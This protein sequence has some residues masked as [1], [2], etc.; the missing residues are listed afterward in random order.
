M[1]IGA[2][3]GFFLAKPLNRVLGA[4]F[5]TFNQGFDFSTG[6]YTRIVGRS[7][8]V[9]LLVLV[10]YGGLLGLTYVSFAATPTGFD[11]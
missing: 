9:S 6:V 4:V 1:V 11:S 5:A 8:R 10:L 3:A 7:L 2:L